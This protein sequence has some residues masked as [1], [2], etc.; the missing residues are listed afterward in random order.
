M[1]KLHQNFR[2][3]CARN[4]DG[5]R[6]TQ[7]NRI[8]MLN[9][10]ANQLKKAGFDVS[11]MSAS[12]LKGRHVNALVRTWKSEGITNATMKNRMA[13][14]RWWAEK[15]NNPGAVQKNEVYGIE[16]R[17]FVTN[18]DKGLRLGDGLDLS[19]VSKE[20][21]ASLKLQSAF[22]LRREE[23]MKFQASYA[24]AGQSI[25]GCKEI[26]IKG[27]WAKG[28]RA[29]TIPITNERQREVLEEVFKVCGTGSLIPEKKTYKSH[30]SVFERETSLL[31]LGRTHGLR[32]NYAQARY[33]ELTGVESPARGG[34]E[35]PE[36]D[37]EARLQI[38]KE[39]GHNRI[40]ITSVYLGS[41]KK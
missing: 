5:S 36:N 30:L 7:A 18:V 4:K 9:L 35:Q 10:F 20:V 37:K 40:N 24:L 2:N 27:S 14:V 28:G 19:K 12:D 26:R 22:G 15:V 34:K 16:N 41:W 39:L 23:S 31:G 29:R 13:V 3:L 21:A 33:K 11:R 32:H 17:V 1:A 6:A 38:S 8:S 25:R